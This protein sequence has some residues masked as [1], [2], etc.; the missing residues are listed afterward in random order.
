MALSCFNNFKVYDFQIHSRQET[1]SITEG[2]GPP[3][4]SQD[5][6]FPWR[7]Q[8]DYQVCVCFVKNKWKW[9]FLS[10]CR[11]WM[12]IVKPCATATLWIFGKV[13]KGGTQKCLLQSVLF[14]IFSISCLKKTYPESW[15]YS[16][17]SISCSKKPFLSSQNLQ[18]K[19][20][21][22]KV[23][24]PPFGTFPKIHPIW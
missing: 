6:N 7:G 15:N 11:G 3:S 19:F 16:F 5:C 17:V 14:L 23:P 1:F 9:S 13:L 10:Q 12:W 24:P 20:L 8:L 22:W 18:Y 2:S 21:D 4:L